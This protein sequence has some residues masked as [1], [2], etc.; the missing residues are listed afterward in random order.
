MEDLI[1]FKSEPWPEVDGN[2]YYQSYKKKGV[3]VNWWSRNK[4]SVF[5]I[6]ASFMMAKDES[7]ISD[8]QILERELPIETPYWLKPDNTQQVGSPGVRATWLGH[9]TVLAEVDGTVVLCDPIFSERASMF[10]W[11]GPKR[12]RPPACTVDQLPDQLDGV[13]I[14]HTH[15]DH[16][17]TNSIYQLHK[18]YPELQWY[19]PSGVKSWFQDS[20]IPES[21]V[22][23]MVWWEE[24]KLPRGE[25]AKK[26]K[27]VFTPSNH[28]SR[29]SAND[30]NTCLWG[31]WTVIGSKGNKFWFGGDTAYSDV[32]EQI[33]R[34]FGHINLAAIPIGAYNPRKTMRFVHV[35]PEE[36]V[37]IHEDIGS[38]KSVGIHWGTFRLTY[39]HFL[40]PK[41]KILEMVNKS[42]LEEGKVLNFEVVNIGATVEGVV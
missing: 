5:N 22:N 24:S 16:M 21:H 4:P 40:E 7:G 12:Y 17:D 29:R 33:G 37:Q 32:F 13:V 1:D 9:A 35:N 28:W 38:L 18:K 20:G 31:S 19:V 2:G 23:E 41:N 3:W 8:Q 36:A 6:G 30:E 39:E 15:Y 26:A 10:Q 14:S 34:R 11:M 42:K 27:F 25:E